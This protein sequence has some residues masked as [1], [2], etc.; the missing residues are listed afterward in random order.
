MKVIPADM[1]QA[2]RVVLKLDWNEG[3]D[4]AGSHPE[5]FNKDSAALDKAGHTLKSC[6][7]FGM[8][9]KSCSTAIEK[10]VLI[11]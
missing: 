2:K 11:L 9:L 8:V 10:E 4:G 7:T 5:L 1:L 6:Q 3:M